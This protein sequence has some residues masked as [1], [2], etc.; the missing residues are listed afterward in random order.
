MQTSGE[1]RERNIPAVL[2]LDPIDV[3]FFIRP[4]FGWD[5]G[6]CVWD[7]VIR[8]VARKCDKDGLSLS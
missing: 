1:G 3:T 5:E 4:F 7:G 8:W 6:V 2:L